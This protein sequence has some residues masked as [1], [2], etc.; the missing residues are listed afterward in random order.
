MPK[1]VE[2]K[3]NKQNLQKI[4][5][6]IGELAKINSRKDPMNELKKEYFFVKVEDSDKTYTKMIFQ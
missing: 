3:Q 5:W 6:K 1:K 2:Q 4:N